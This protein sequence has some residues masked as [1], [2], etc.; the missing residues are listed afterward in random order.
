MENMATINSF[1]IDGVIDIDGL[2]CIYPS[3]NDIIITGRSYIEEHDTL[4][5]L[6]DRGIRNTV[7]FNPIKFDEKTRE[8]SGL[9][10]AN[11]LK[12]LKEND[13]L[14]I[15]FHIEDDEIQKAII[16]REC[17]WITVIHVVHN[18]TEKEN[19]LRP[20]KKE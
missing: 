17:P 13:N 15:K 18:L 6:R 11:I 10:K 2:P 14:N 12:S 16:E 1:D 5:M 4:R 9:H 20:Y 7:F 8:S 3:P 19:I